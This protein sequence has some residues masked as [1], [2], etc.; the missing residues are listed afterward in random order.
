ME[1]DGQQGVHP[2]TN[3]AR[4]F[5]QT[6]VTQE[7]R[8]VSRGQK[9][10]P[11]KAALQAQDC[12]EE[13]RE[14]LPATSVLGPHRLGQCSLSYSPSPFIFYCLSQGLIKLSGKDWNL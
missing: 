7:K 12:K 1:R 6:E 9:K 4:L 10:T 14:L 2:C 13:S 8:L 3:K 11:W 5:P